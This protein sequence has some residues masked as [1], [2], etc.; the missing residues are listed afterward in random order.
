ML[1]RSSNRACSSTTAVTCLPDRDAAMSESTI[2]LSDPVRYSVCMM[3]STSG[4]LA[5]RSTNASTDAANDSYG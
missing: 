3:A 2:E 1:A 4:S 5:E